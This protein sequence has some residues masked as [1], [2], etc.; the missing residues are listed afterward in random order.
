MV[1]KRNLKPIKIIILVVIIIG[2]ILS[3]ATIIEGILSV[4]SQRIEQPYVV[5]TSESDQMQTPEPTSEFNDIEVP[6]PYSGGE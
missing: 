5:V 1:Q 3:V 6:D 2:M 4:S